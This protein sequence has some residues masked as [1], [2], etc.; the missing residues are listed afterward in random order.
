M[1][2]C[3][4]LVAE[5]SRAHERIAPFIRETYLQFSPFYSELTGASV[6]FKCEN[7]QLTGSF[8]LRGALNKYLSLTSSERQRGVVAASTGN[9]GKAVAYASRVA[10]PESQCPCMIFAPTDADPLKLKA[11]RK[12]GADVQL[13][14]FDCVEAESNARE[15]SANH[16]Q[17]YISPYNDSDVIAGQG[18]IGLE[19]CKQL[20]RVDAVIGSVGG[21][22]MLG[23]IASFVRDQFPDCKIIGC[24]PENS[25]VMIQSLAKGRLLDLPSTETLSDGTAGGV[26]AGSITFEVCQQHITHPVSVT[27]TE[28]A[29]CLVE[30]IDRQGMLIEGAAAVAIAALLRS[31]Q[32]LAGKN[33]VVV[34]C[35]ANISTQRLKSITS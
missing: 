2:E 18:T 11:I 30:F 32:Q 22:G 5:I 15:F 28:I 33:V 14:G 6:Y 16:S 19:I 9:H 27:E 24:S 4:S 34:L 3:L 29:D 12:M 17:T 31:S 8:K 23:G 20:E 26:E 21:G 1:P 13:S 10:N 25:N 7:L 35:G